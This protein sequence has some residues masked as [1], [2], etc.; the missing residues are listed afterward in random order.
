[1]IMIKKVS[2]LILMILIPITMTACIPSDILVSDEDK[3]VSDEQIVLSSLSGSDDRYV[4]DIQG[5]IYAFQD[6]GYLYKTDSKFSSYEKV[7]NDMIYVIDI[8]DGRVYYTYMDGVKDGPFYSCALDGSDIEKTMKDDT[9]WKVFISGNNMYYSKLSVPDSS[10]K[11]GF[12]IMDMTT[13]GQ[14]KINDDVPA[15]FIEVDGMLYYYSSWGNNNGI[16][17]SYDLKTGEI[18]DALTWENI[19]R[20]FPDYVIGGYIYYDNYVNNKMYRIRTDGTEKE[21]LFNHEEYDFGYWIK[22]KDGKGYYKSDS[23]GT[24]DLMTG[25]E[26]PLYDDYDD[27]TS[28][29]ILNDTIYFNK[30]VIGDSPKLCRM[31]LDGSNYREI[32][33]D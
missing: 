3:K 16:L 33:V 24:I 19:M 22:I 14:K 11:D 31:D 30:T 1:M 7:I 6:F 18:K 29:D 15:K 8:I 9:V 25:K 20:F 17:K 32:G 28:L 13:K 2:I 12:Y 5:D 23:I 21:E 4:W 27:C 26:T 10:S